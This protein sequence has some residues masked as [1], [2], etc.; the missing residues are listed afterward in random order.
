[1]H[2]LV[3]HRLG[4]IEHCA[5][6]CTSFMTLTGFQASGKSTIAKAIYFF[7]TIK[8]D[9]ASLAE[10]QA[11]GGVVING[12]EDEY[13]YGSEVSLEEAL[14]N[15]L[16]KKFFSTFGLSGGKVNETY[17][18]YYFTQTCSITIRL[19]QDEIK[20]PA[21]AVPGYL[22]II[23]SDCL[24]TF[25]QEKNHCF[26]A[27]S[28]GVSREKK[29]QLNHE[30]YQLFDDDCTVVYIPA[31]RSMITLLSRQFNYI[32]ATMGDD[33]KQSLDVCTRDYIER[34]LRLK[35]EF[36]DGIQHV[37]TH[38]PGKSLSLFIER[39]LALNLIKKILKGDYRYN[40]GE[41]QI[42]LGDG[43]YVKLNF[44]SSGQQECV[45]ILNLLFYYLMQKKPVL[46]IIEEPES[47]LFPESQKYITE[48]IALVN[49]CGHSIVLTT[50]SPYVLGTLNNLLY[51]YTIP[52]QYRKKA[53]EIIHAWIWL[54]Y[55]QFNSWFVKDGTIE[56]CMDDE[57][58]MIQNEKID[59]ISKVINQDFDQLLDLQSTD[60]DGVML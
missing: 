43:N 35:P 42:L 23:F 41:E 10:R 25:L 60:E 59:E 17:M 29:N 45:W 33:Q 32:Y 57:I 30:L 13:Y 1:M 50:H 47:H 5:L 19:K 11:L 48:L 28:L 6:E 12:I 7:R 39:G 27:T 34:T 38:S 14:E 18:E 51:A 22:Q 54:N 31:G 16:Q 53:S 36:S 9:I 8:E 46:F 44:A 24:R 52:S 26:F 40:N 20:C 21:H 4:P 37:T 3:I 58:H 55:Q 56:T 15:A 49:H 2:K